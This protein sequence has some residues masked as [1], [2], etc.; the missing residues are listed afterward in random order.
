V[1]VDHLR[2]AGKLTVEQEATYLEIDDWFQEH[3]PNPD[4]YADGNSIGAVTWF[5]DPVPSAMQ[6]RV[7][8][9]RAIL[10]AHEVEFD[11]VES[12][13]PGE[14]VYDD[15]FQIGV[16]PYTRA[17]PTPLPDGAVLAPTSAGSKRAVAT[18][19][20]R[21]VLFDADGVL[22]IVPGGWYAAMEPYLGDRAREFLHQTW[23]DELPTLAGEADYLPMLA[24]TLVEYGV[25]EPVDAVYRAV[26]HRI[27]RIEESFA[28]IEALRRNGYGVHLGTN[29]ER[30]RGGHMR[31]VL[32]YD[33]IFDTSCYSYDLGVAKPD[34][35]FFTEAARQIGA[36]SSTILFID[37][38]IRNVE[39]AW[40]AGLEAAVWD[41]EQGHDALIALLAGYGVDARMTA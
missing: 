36:E 3:L 21:H 7:E 27:D 22:Q 23:K 40:A 4:F 33:D 15:E 28:I 1:A 10:R 11:T 6:S 9:M 32:G 8:E 25:T 24:A 16:V 5:K 37:D 35:A 2:R 29:Q 39:G 26:W 34:P 14:I 17:A 38:N 31:T 18:S 13:D 20:I 30:H 19:A 41:V 12:D